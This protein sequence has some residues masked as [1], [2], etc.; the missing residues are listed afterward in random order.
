VRDR[1]MVDATPWVR[2]LL[3]VLDEFHRTG[4]VV[5]DQ[6]AART[7]NLYMGEISETSEVFARALGRPEYT[8]RYGREERARSEAEA[9]R[10]HFRRVAA[11]LDDFHRA[12]RF[13]LL[14]IGGHEHEIPAFEAFLPH[15]LRATVAGTFAIDP[16]TATVAGVRAGA[17]PILDRYEREEEQRWVAETLERAARG[18]LAALGL[19][20]CLWAGSVSGIQRLLVQDGSV[21]PGV[22]CDQSGWLGVSGGTCPLCGEPTRT[23]DDVIDELAESVI[24]AGGSV[25]HVLGDTPLRDHLLAADLRFPPPP[26]PRRG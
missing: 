20:R 14:V 16:N 15:S 25:E 3:A 22:V 26:R 4:V 6:E 23:T 17:E 2:P 1:I 9:V 24:D 13:E 21:A 11:V 7:W 19:E 5:V 12:G 10:R 8:G 18:S